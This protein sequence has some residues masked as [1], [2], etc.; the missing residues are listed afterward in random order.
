M[1]KKFL[2]ERVLIPIWDNIIL[3]SFVGVASLY[4]SQ[5]KLFLL[6]HYVNLLVFVLVSLFFMVIIILLI[7]KTRKLLKELKEIKHHYEDFAKL[8]GLKIYKDFAYFDPNVGPSE[9]YC[10]YCIEENNKKIR[11]TADEPFYDCSSCGKRAIDHKLQNRLLEESDRAI[12]F[13]D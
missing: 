2:K 11:L 1:V 13:F 5:V 10:K 9:L 7:N 8:K 4:I 6:N 12:S 3:I